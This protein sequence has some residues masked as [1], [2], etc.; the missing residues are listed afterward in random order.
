MSGMLV[1]PMAISRKLREVFQDVIYEKNMQLVG[2]SLRDIV[3]LD[4][5]GVAILVAWQHG[6][7]IGHIPVDKEPDGQP[8]PDQARVIRE[9]TASFV[10][11]PVRKFRNDKAKLVQMGIL[12][13]KADP[14]WFIYHEDGL[15]GS[16]SFNTDELTQRSKVRLSKGD[17][18]EILSVL[19]NQG[20]LIPA[21]VNNRQIQFKDLAAK[22]VIEA[23]DEQVYVKVDHPFK[24]EELILP[25]KYDIPA[26]RKSLLNT[27]RFR[28]A[29]N[30]CSAQ[31]LSPRE[32]TIH[33]AQISTARGPGCR[34]RI[35]WGK[36]R[37]VLCYW[38]VLPPHM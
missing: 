37:Q 10:H 2:E 6:I 9:A 20:F 22:Q 7:E 1:E 33:S 8:K 34:S 28:T 21:N 4:G 18:R 38:Q 29:C 23:S 31:A 11:V 13:K 25:E 15:V 5:L 17:L 12:N 14:V 35:A 16:F 19:A 36:L 26:I 27:L 24:D 30:Y 32:A 3:A